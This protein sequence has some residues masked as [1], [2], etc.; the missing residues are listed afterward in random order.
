MSRV[1]RR[2]KK[3]NKK[4]NNLKIKTTT[5][6]TNKQTNE[7]PQVACVNQQSSGSSGEFTAHYLHQWVWIP[8][9]P[10]NNDKCK[11]NPKR[12]M[13]KRAIHV[14]LALVSVWHAISFCWLLPPIYSISFSCMKHRYNFSYC[15]TKDIV[16]GSPWNIGL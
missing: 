9:R 14:F 13:E 7:K 3:N 4:T 8:L 12:K 2:K 10:V 5:M 1:T 11:R 6:T 16:S 15:L